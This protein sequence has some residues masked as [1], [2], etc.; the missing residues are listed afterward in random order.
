MTEHSESVRRSGFHLGI[1]VKILIP[2]ILMNIFIGVVLSSVI[3]SEF[4]NQCI[5]TGAQGALSIV[6][7]AEARINGDTM[8]KLANEG[9]N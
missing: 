8:Q 9:M 6:T 3:M 2:V 7:L 1:R 5:E 4:R